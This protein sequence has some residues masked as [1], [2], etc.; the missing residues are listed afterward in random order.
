MA[1]EAVVLEELEE[2]FEVLADF[3]AEFS[4][5][6]SLETLALLFDGGRATDE[7]DCEFELFLLKD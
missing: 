3:A 4:R 2:A 5:F 7:P 1:S 6:P